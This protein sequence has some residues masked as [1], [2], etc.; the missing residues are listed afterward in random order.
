M[1]NDD[2]SARYPG[3]YADYIVNHQRR[4]G[5]GTLAGWRGADGSQHGVGDPNPDQ[6]QRYIDNG[7]FWQ[8]ELPP[9][10]RYFKHGNRDYLE[11]A[12]R[13]GFIGAAKPIVIQ[14]YSEV[15][16]KF[17]LAAR[18]HG[19]VTPPPEYRERIEHYFDPL[20]FWYP[21]FEGAALASGDFPL[22]ALTQR[23]MIMYHAW[24]SQNAWQRQI[25]GSN[26]LYLHP[27]TAA[28][29]GIVDDGW[30]WVTSHHGRIKCQVRLMAGVNP[31]T[32]WTWNAI[33][34]RAG[35]WNLDPDAGEA[36]K[37]FLLNHLIAETLPGGDHSNSDPVTG[38]AAWFDLRV[39]IEPAEANTP[40]HSEPQFAVLPVPPGLPP[41]PKRLQR[42]ARFRRR[43]AS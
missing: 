29:L 33:G 8:D 12:A 36:R 32:V 38:Q 27:Q 24:D 31:D 4:P 20:P 5:I 35:A 21:P 19:A 7:C 41:A 3:G 18:G 1:T 43:A 2:G 22:H 17:R 10:A 15:M 34:K 39:R 40:A 25:L 28:R 6:L 37:G 11:Y 9:E 23:P 42:G 26:R 14:L 30:V 16:Q 13:M